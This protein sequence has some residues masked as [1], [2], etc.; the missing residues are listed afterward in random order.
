MLWL[1]LAQVGVGDVKP[2]TVKVL[3][4]TRNEYVRDTLDVEILTFSEDGGVIPLDTVRIFGGGDTI[5]PPAFHVI[6]FNV[7]YAGEVFPSNVVV[8]GR[9]TAVELFVYDITDDTSA[10]MLL[11]ENIGIIRDRGGYR[12]V[13]VFFILNRSKFAFRG[14]AVR[15][16][17]PEAAVEVS[18]STGQEDI[19]RQGDEVILNPLILP[20]EGNFA[21]SYLVVKDNFA[22]EREGAGNYKLLVDTLVPIEVKVGRF[23]GMEEFEGEII[24][25]WESN[26]RISFYVGTPPIRR[27]LLYYLL[28]ALFVL[29]GVA[30]MALLRRWIL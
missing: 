28:G 8:V 11:A 19:L 23:A 26:N 7:F 9:D 18:L 21:L 4:L 14:P 29:V 10:L 6:G 16:R 22:V 27:E 5:V 25:V 30:I 13:E 24:R 17:L 3:N 1:W 20:G 12:V 2:I 15:V